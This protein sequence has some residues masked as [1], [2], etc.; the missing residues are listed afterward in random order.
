MLNNFLSSTQSIEQAVEMTFSGDYACDICN[1]V[2]EGLEDNKEDKAMDDY[3]VL[4]NKPI[5]LG[6]ESRF[7]LVF[8]ENYRRIIESRNDSFN[9]RFEAP[10]LQPPRV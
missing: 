6:L 3:L 10:P 4:E 1:I 5:I 8:P 2:F 7:S 9:L